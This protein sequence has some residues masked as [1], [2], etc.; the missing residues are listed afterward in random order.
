VP[1]IPRRLVLAPVACAVVLAGVAL[2]EP[3]APSS[4]AETPL[5]QGVVARVRGHDVTVAEFHRHLARRLAGE[6]DDEKSPTANTFRMAVEE[7]VVDQEARR[8]GIAV[9]A[10]DVD[11]RRAEIEAALR[12]KSAG[13]ASLD[14]LMKE[15]RTS[16]DEF[17]RN[18]TIQVTKEKVA[19]HPAY[20]GPRLPKEENARL[21]QIEVVMGQILARAKVD[22]E[23]L[24]EGVVAKVNGEPFTEEEFG[25][26]IDLRMRTAKYLAEYVQS[27]LLK[28]LTITD[29][30]FDEAVAQDR[31]VFE[32]LREVDPQPEMRTISYEQFVEATQGRPLA[33]LRRDPYFRGITALKARMRR[34]VTEDDVRKEWVR[35]AA[36]RYGAVLQVLDLQVSFKIPNTVVEHV[37][38]R[39]RE[40]AQRLVA[41]YARRIREKEPVAG[42]VAEIEARKTPD[43][44]PDRSIQA[45]PRA[46]RDTDNGQMLFAAAKDLADGQWSA[47]VETISEFHLVRRDRLVPAPTFEEARDQVRQDVVVTRANAW[48]HDQLNDPSVVRIASK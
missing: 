40:E 6:L 44:R 26:Q 47:P 31:V 9:T 10:A 28:D 20:L 34:E 15:T 38:R 21:A 32:R 46:V 3:P 37:P 29:A 23:A 35:N 1:E 36:K 17:R 27:L 13:K 33:D 22:R 4:S 30:E 39:S 41:D 14:D 24:P 12:E 11:A 8:L 45:V 5:P 42:I 25:H 48:L 2:A 18:L 7:R 19:A 16:P 43:G